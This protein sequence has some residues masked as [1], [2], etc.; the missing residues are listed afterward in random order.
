MDNSNSFEEAPLPFK[1]L[2]QAQPAGAA[3]NEVSVKEA[4]AKLA[5]LLRKVEAGERIVLT[6]HGKPVADLVPHGSATGTEEKPMSLLE[7]VEA[8]HKEHPSKGIGWIAPDFD[9]ALPEDFLLQPFPEDF[10]E[11]LAAA[12]QRARDSRRR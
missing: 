10:D 5:E 12:N 11:K 7:R 2:A 8:W 9:D 4:K 6:R 1:H 3:A